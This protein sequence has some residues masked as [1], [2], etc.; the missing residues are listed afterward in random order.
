VLYAV[1]WSESEIWF[2]FGLCDEASHVLDSASTRRFLAQHFEIVDADGVIPGSERTRRHVRAYLQSKFT[3]QRVVPGADR[4]AQ[5]DFEAVS[6]QVEQLIQPIQSI[7]SYGLDEWAPSLYKSRWLPMRPD[8]SRYSAMFYCSS[9]ARY[10]PSMLSAANDGG[11]PAWLLGGFVSEARIHL[12]RDAVR[13]V[14]GQ[15][16]EMIEGRRIY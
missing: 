1:S 6:R 5:A 7:G 11:G 10:R 3:L 9:V 8:L 13:G 2:T 12:L 4:P 14:T 16:V 15:H